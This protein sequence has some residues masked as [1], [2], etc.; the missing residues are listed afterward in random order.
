LLLRLTDLGN[1]FYSTNV[2][3]IGMRFSRGGATV[4]IIYPGFYHQPD[5]QLLSGRFALYAGGH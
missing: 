1:K 2:P 4:N 5:H 3:G